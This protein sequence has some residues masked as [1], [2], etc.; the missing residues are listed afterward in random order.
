MTDVGWNFLVLLFAF[1]TRFWY[2]KQCAV[3]QS[4]N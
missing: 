3:M 4:L 2:M 1:A